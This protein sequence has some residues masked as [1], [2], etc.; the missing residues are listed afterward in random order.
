MRAC[1]NVYVRACVC[2]LGWYCHCHSV[3]SFIF[4]F[5]CY[6]QIFIFI[7]SS[8]MLVFYIFRQFSYSY[9]SGAVFA[10]LHVVCISALW[11]AAARLGPPRARAGQ[12]R[13]GSEAVDLSSCVGRN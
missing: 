11:R 13:S 7:I 1:V 6:E 9:C 5:R 2:V 3:F 4:I 8:F 12:S 10:P